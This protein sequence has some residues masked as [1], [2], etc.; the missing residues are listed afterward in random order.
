MLLLATVALAAPLALAFGYLA[1]LLL[2]PLQTSAFS[3]AVGAGFAYVALVVF[4]LHALCAFCAPHG[5]AG[6]HFR[7]RPAVLA[8]FRSHT[9]WLACIGIPVLFSATVVGS[10]AVTAHVHSLG[11]ISFM[12]LQAGCQPGQ[13]F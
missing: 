3:R 12:S 5:V 8:R 11:R 6:A 9:S 1:W 2:V 10:Q 4:A 13:C 7:W